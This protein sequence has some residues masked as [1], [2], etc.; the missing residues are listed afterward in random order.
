MMRRRNCFVAASLLGASLS[1]GVIGIGAASAG[2]SSNTA[3]TTSTTSSGLLG[4]LG[5][6]SLLGSLPAFPTL[7]SAPSVSTL[8]PPVCTELAGT[9]LC[10]TSSTIAAIQEVSSIQNWLQEFT[11]ALAQKA[12]TL[13]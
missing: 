9:P 1:L 6:S 12:P 13:P 4:G 8:L 11:S 5:L 10:G 3:T 2:A 7:S